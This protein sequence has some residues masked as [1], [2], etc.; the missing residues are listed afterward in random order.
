[1]QCSVTCIVQISFAVISNLHKRCL[2]YNT[3]VWEILK[4]GDHH[5]HIQHYPTYVTS[6]QKH[7]G[8]I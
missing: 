2:F 4:V 7:I 1:M 3:R 5:C 6:I 8:Q